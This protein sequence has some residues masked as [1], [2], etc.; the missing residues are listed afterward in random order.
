MP[1][2]NECSS[3]RLYADANR[4][5]FRLRNRER[6]TVW[7]SFSLSFPSPRGEDRF[8]RLYLL[9]R[10]HARIDKKRAKRSELRNAFYCLFTDGLVFLSLIQ[11]FAQ[12]YVVGQ[13]WPF[14]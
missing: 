4:T 5:S 14:R 11:G 7:L 3:E 12:R 9:G 1:P 2:L 10:C 8:G 13:E 6:Q